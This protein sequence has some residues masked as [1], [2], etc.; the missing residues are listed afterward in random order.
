MNKAAWMNRASELGLEGFEITQSRNASRALEWFEG[1][2]DSY[3]VSRILSTSFRALYDGKIVSTSSER[4][5]DEDMDLVLEQLK[6]AALSVSQTEKDIFNPVM[7][8]ETVKSLHTWKEPEVSQIKELLASLE[9]KLKKADPRVT[10]VDGVGWED[11]RSQ[12]ELSNSLGVEVTDGGTLQA[13]YASITM[14]ENGNLRDGFWM[15]LVSDIDEFDQDAFVENLIEKV[16]SQLSARSMKS[17][18]CPVIIKREAMS[19]LFSAFSGMFSGSL[20]AKGISPLTGKVKEK[21]FSDK[22]TVIDDPRNQQALFL[23]NYDD[24]GHPTYEKTVVNHGIFETVLHN[25]KSALKMNTQST[26][27]GFKS[28][29]GAT[30]V[31]CMNL[32]IVPGD[33]DL[34]QLEEEMGDGVVIDTLEGLHA[35][36][37][38][39]STNFSLQARGYKVKD[40]KKE[41]PLTL[42]TLAGNF[43]EMMNE[44]TAVGSDLEWKTR[45]VACPSILFKEAAIGGNE[46]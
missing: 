26:G 36:I 18:V 8:T 31:S 12:S 14:E 4:V 6:S 39:V 21:V 15:E 35:G 5:K 16:S 9:E 24:E 20:I 23:Q 22:I 27:N 19:S 42:I 25:T 44:V 3:T 7:E 28:G 29:G 43:L 11:S 38:F 40:G 13:V 41:R 37:D 1:T 2:L 30:S 46:E 33:L 34:H 10:K 17:R 32:Y 45:N